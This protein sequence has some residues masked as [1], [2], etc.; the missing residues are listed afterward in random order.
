MVAL[1]GWHDGDCD[2]KETESK[3]SMLD[4]DGRKG[5]LTYV[6]FLFANHIG[7]FK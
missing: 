6:R 1:D 4:V 7:A 2:D 5:P 3:C